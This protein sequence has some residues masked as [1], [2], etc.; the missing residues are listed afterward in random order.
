MHIINKID[1]ILVSF[2]LALFGAIF[3]GIASMAV[4]LTIILPLAVIVIVGVELLNSNWTSAL[5]T[6]VIRIIGFY[7]LR[8]FFELIKKISNQNE[9]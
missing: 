3:G 5:Q 4:F 2:S 9:A 1:K 8:G 7:L 6:F